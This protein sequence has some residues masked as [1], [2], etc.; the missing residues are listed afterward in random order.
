MAAPCRWG[1]AGTALEQ[2]PNGAGLIFSAR[3]TAET[4]REP[5]EKEKPVNNAGKTKPT[6]LWMF[7][8]ALSPVC[9]IN[10]EMLLPGWTAPPAAKAG[11]RE[12]W[13]CSLRNFSSRDI[14]N[15]I[16]GMNPRKLGNWGVR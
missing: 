4:Q 8:V 5:E 10:F 12:G 3:D 1:W 13:L 15:A 11:I 16:S 6:V 2:L 14:F 7:G 9:I